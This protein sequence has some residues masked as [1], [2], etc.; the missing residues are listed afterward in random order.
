MKKMFASLVTA[1]I[2][3]ICALTVINYSYDT[4]A[5]VVTVGSE[6]ANAIEVIETEDLICDR[7]DYPTGLNEESQYEILAV[8]HLYG[9]ND[10]GDYVPAETRYINGFPTVNGVKSN[11]KYYGYELYIFPGIEEKPYEDWNLY[12]FHEHGELL[13][14]EGK[15]TYV[16]PTVPDE[17]TANDSSSES[18]NIFDWTQD[19]VDDVNENQNNVLDIV[20]SME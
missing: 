18:G 20:D 12:D 2:I 8:N 17:T 4:S 11:T 14:S 6:I 16:T 19:T 10:Y 3:G 15:G 1:F 9:H 5:D 13:E 7:Q